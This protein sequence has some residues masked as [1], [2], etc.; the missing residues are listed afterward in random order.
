M[1]YQ[2][3][4]SILVL[5]FTACMKV[6]KKGEVENN[7]TETQVEQRM[8]ELKSEQILDSSDF[9]IIYSGEKEPN[10]YSVN[11]KWP[12]L[13]NSVIRIFHSGDDQGAEIVENSFMMQ[14]KKGGQSEKIRIEQYDTATEKRKSVFTLEIKPPEDLVFSGLQVLSEDLIKAAERLFILA[15]ARIYAQQFNLKIKTH[16]IIAEEGSLITNFPS[17]SSADLEK[18]GLSGGLIEIFST[19]AV[20]R[21]KIVLNGQSGGSGRLGTPE[22]KLFDGMILRAD[23]LVSGST[24]L[25]SCP[26]NSGG[27]GG[28]SGSLVFSVDESKDFILLSDIELSKSGLSGET[29]FKCFETHIYYEFKKLCRPVNLQKCESNFDL[30]QKSEGSSG[31][32]CIK[33]DQKENFK[34]SKK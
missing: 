33:L 2:I 3:G 23:T 10:Q 29:N 28:K 12:Q 17:D 14:N 4:L 32:M 30:H 9:Q 7:A 18:V 24:L 5:A 27:Q 21:L 13:K 8:P 19:E 1:N 26:G 20:G 34:C 22:A 31:Q 16:K 25:Q 11:L 6:T 15:D